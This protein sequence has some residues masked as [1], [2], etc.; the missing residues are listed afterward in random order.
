MRKNQKGITLIALVI[1]IIVLLILAGVSIA[2]LRGDNNIVKNAT[3]A[4]IK[5]T[6]AE[7]KEMIKLAVNAVN[8]EIQGKRV[9]VANW[10]P[11][12][13]TNDKALADLFKKDL[14][15]DSVYTSASSMTSLKNISEA[16]SETE[17]TYKVNGTEY[18]YKLTYDSDSAFYSVEFT[19][20]EA[21]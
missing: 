19:D 18:K 17:Q 20:E 16:E 7:A 12:E 8:M 11:Q 4:K 6:Q 14:T 2:M 1:T 3:D 21:E 5:T 15:D 13:E 10:D 9:D